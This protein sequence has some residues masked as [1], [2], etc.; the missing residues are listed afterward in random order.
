MALSNLLRLAALGG[1]L[2]C[3]FAAG[4][5]MACGGSTVAYEDKFQ[6]LDP[7]WGSVSQNRY[8]DD[9]RLV[10]K[11]EVGYSYVALNQ[12]GLFADGDICA[13][14][15]VNKI[16]D[17]GG[18][19]YGIVFWALDTDNFFGFLIS[20]NGSYELSH[21][22]NGRILHPVSWTDSPAIKKGAKL[23]NELEV[24]VKGQHLILLIN[25]TKVREIDAAPPTG[26]GMVGVYAESP[27][28]SQATVKFQQLRVAN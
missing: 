10:L 9:S 21:R 28:Q 18:T 1:A 26:G 23:Y 7:S 13:V 25:G 8:V 27:A 6:A 20:S 2:A 17:P 24:Q 19:I 16:S 5:V 22:V 11:P 12:S 15:R 3:A 4:P 14:G